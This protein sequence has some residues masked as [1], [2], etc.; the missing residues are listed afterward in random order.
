MRRIFYLILLILFVSCSSSKSQ[1]D[2]DTV[3]DT[4]SDTQDSET[5]DD[6]SDAQ[7]FE[8]VDDSEEMPDIDSDSDSEKSDTD[9]CYPPLSQAAFPYYDKDGK[10]TFCRPDCDAPTADDP[11]CIGNLWDEQNEKLCH[12]YPEYAC[13]GMPCVLESLK[14]MTKEEVDEMY[15]V[16][17][18]AMHK[19]D[20]KI[21]PW[22][23]GHDDSHGVVKAWNMSEGK[24][25]FYTYPVGIGIITWHFF[26]II[27]DFRIL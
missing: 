12:E 16:G 1:N 9:E 11:I 19:C 7:E 18:I 2:S 8:I 24:L 5:I 22:S 13:C 27:N 23:W 3:P 17:K 25:G 21:D 10:I 15:K 14:P 4:D 26:R 20:L 6:D